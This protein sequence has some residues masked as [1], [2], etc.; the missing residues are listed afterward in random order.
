D[1]N[2]IGRPDWCCCPVNRL[3]CPCACARI[4]PAPCGYV[5]CRERGGVGRDA[6][7]HP[8][9]SQQP[10]SADGPEQTPLED[11]SSEDAPLPPALQEGQVPEVLDEK[12]LERD[13]QLP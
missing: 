2:R 3:L 6:V 4:R 13:L 1:L 5:V 7:K 9:W 11:L 12:R 10:P 8:D